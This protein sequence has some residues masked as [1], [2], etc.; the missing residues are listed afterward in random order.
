[1]VLQAN[2]GRDPLIDLYQELMDAIVYARQYLEEKPMG[3]MS[4]V[5][6]DFYDSLISQA[7]WLLFC[8][9][10]KHGSQ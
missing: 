10:S 1:M 6:Q 5:S 8:L 9:E 3:E 4:I 7:G 2:N